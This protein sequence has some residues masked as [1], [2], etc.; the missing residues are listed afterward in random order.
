MSS[1]ALPA[2]A[3]PPAASTW[4]IRLV[5]GCGVA[6]MALL[7]AA[8]LFAHHWGTLADAIVTGW[9]TATL[10][11]AAG[12]WFLAHRRRLSDQ[13]WIAVRIA[14][15]AILATLVVLLFAGVVWA[16]GGDPSGYCGGG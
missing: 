9:A 4:A 3:E 15:G 12:V 16:A 8:L 11:S 7:A 1:K 2:N 5:A 6:S 14:G 13:S 10:T